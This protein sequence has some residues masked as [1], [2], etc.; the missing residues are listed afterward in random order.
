MDEDVISGIM[1]RKSLKIIKYLYINDY[2]TYRVLERKLK[3]DGKSA[4]KYV[5]L[6]SNYGIVKVMKIGRAYVIMLNRGGKY[7]KAVIEFL[8]EVGYLW[9]LNR[10]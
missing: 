3:I 7:T 1:S 5:E 10:Y 6:L 2:A 4:R 9:T 8:R